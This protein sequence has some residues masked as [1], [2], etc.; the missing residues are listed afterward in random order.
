MGEV[1]LQENLESDSLNVIW[2][3]NSKQKNQ[4]LA[5]L[6]NGVRDECIKGTGRWLTKWTAKKRYAKRPFCNPFFRISPSLLTLSS[7]SSIQAVEAVSAI[8]P[9]PRCW[10]SELSCRVHM[11]R[12]GK[13]HFSKFNISDL[14]FKWTV[15]PTFCGPALY[16]EYRGLIR[17]ASNV[18]PI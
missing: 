6:S 13:G 10:C 1:T 12:N 7:V 18:S 2:W 15:M 17:W 9:E 3:N 8:Y 14:N 4:N 5:V 16:W 11:G